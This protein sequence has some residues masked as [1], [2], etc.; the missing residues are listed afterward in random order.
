MPIR[1]TTRPAAALAL[2]LIAAPAGAWDLDC[3]HSAEREL[4]VD[5]AGASRIEIAARAGDL[6][7]RAGAPSQVQA[8][9]RACASTPEF[10]EQTQIRSVR[11]GGTLKVFVQV[12][13][14]MKGI[15]LF[16]ARLDLEVDVPA[17]VPVEVID[18]SGDATITGVRLTKLT[19]SSGDTTLRGITGDFEVND[20]SGD[21]RVENAAGKVT[22]TDSSG[23]IVVRGAQDVVV[24]SD[25]SGD[26]DIARVAGSVRIENDSS[27]DIDVTDVGHD[28]AVLA[29]TSGAVRVS[30]VKGTVSVPD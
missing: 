4:R 26:V 2:A 23:D 30:G 21:L 13:E 16:Y 28:V 6:E 25:S 10:L 29:D 7:V 20:S 14:E 24:R 22:I 5:A 9:G 19:D 18:S 12:P 15:G 1:V 27:G 11:E 8:R 3:R 17:G